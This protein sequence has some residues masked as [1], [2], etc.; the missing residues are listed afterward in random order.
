MVTLAKHRARDL[1][2]DYVSLIAG[3]AVELPGI[4]AFSNLADFDASF[5]QHHQ[6]FV[7]PARTANFQNIGLSRLPP[8]TVVAA[9]EGYPTFVGDTYIEEQLAPWLIEDEGRRAQARLPGTPVQVPAGEYLLAARFGEGTWGHW[10]AEILPR[11]VVAEHFFPGRFMFVVPGW[12]THLNAGMRAYLESIYAYGIDEA[13]LFRIEE[14][15][16]YAFESLHLLDS[17][18]SDR[19]M[20]PDVLDFMRNNL[21]RGVGGVTGYLPARVGILRKD[22]ARRAISNHAEVETFLRA[23]GF[24]VMELSDLPFLSQVSLF[25]NASCVFCVLGSGLTNTLYSPDH[26]NVIAP[27]PEAWGDS[28]FYPLIQARNGRFADVRGTI[29]EG[30]RNRPADS[31]FRVDIPTLRRGFEALNLL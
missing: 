3:R 30:D 13:R 25:R 4:A 22:S 15:H 27:A 6:E 28:F 31:R 11:I 8:G 21:P 26:V 14:T 16:D 17:V 19:S 29:T 10:L 20:H 24:L 9:R 7:Y 12:T 2:Q 1:A 23:N 5:H 18:W